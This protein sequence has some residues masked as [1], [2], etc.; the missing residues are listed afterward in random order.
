MCD[1]ILFIGGAYKQNQRWEISETIL[2][3]RYVRI[4]RINL[5]TAQSASKLL[6]NRRIMLRSEKET[7]Q[8]YY[9]GCT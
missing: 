3:P 9:L 8:K 1:V 2:S 5:N 4:N 7:K 6:K